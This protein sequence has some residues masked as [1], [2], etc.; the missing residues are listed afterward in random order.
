MSVVAVDNLPRPRIGPIQLPGPALL[1]ALAGYSDLPYRLLCREQ[2]AD[3]CS[4]EVTLDKSINLSVKLR[5][6]LIQIN[7][8]DHPL[9]V[10]IMG[11]EAETLATAAR[12]AA[13]MGADVIDLNFACP[14]RKVLRRR[15]GGHLMRDPQTALAMIEA[16]RAAVDLPIMLK[17]RAGFD[18]DD[19]GCDAMWRIAEGG[20]ERGVSAICLHPRTV[21]QHYTGP[22]DWDLLKRFRDHFADRT[23]FGSGDL[24]DAR[25]GH[26]MLSETGVDGVSFARGA[27]GNPWVFRQFYQLARGEQPTAPSLDEQ[28]EL[29]QRHYQ[30]CLD[31]YGE[32]IAP[33]MMYRFG[34]KY[35]ALHPTPKA[36][37]QAF[38]HSKSG[39][40]FLDILD[41]YYREV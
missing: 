29:I 34:I 39:Q 13:G 19:H 41:V 18:R 36:V 16:V 35:S 37:R 3:F 33:R 31:A 8:A 7:E 10:Q 38:I 4:T 1:A 11:A 27:L 15:R 2:G 14:V 21:E 23:V 28:R 20:F 26:R 6:K 40:K 25:A 22:S 9:A 30:L 24:W 17:I 12:H 5:N 32:T